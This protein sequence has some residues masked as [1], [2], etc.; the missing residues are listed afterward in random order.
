MKYGRAFMF[1]VNPVN[2]DSMRATN[3]LE[4]VLTVKESARVL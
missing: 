2:L 3:G 4:S 1:D